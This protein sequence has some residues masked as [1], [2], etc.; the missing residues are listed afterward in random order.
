MICD[1]HLKNKFT[2][3]NTEATERAEA[4]MAFLRL[5]CVLCGKFSS[6]CESEGVGHA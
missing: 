4:S 1:R 2:T 3:E 5:L 6:I